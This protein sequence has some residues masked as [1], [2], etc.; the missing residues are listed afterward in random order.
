MTNPISPKIK[1]KIFALRAEGLSNEN[2]GKKLKISETTV[3][4]YLAK[5]SVEKSTTDSTPLT[6]EA[7]K[8]KR[9][10][11]TRDKR[12]GLIDRGLTHLEAM[13]PGID[14]P[15]GMRDW[16]VALGTAIDKRR[17]E[18]PESDASG[19]AAIDIFIEEMK[20]EAATNQP[21]AIEQH[22]Q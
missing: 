12:V 20:R 18:L 22:P 17:L 5:S 2:I 16:F 11:Y 7:A 19:V 8:N 6:N 1:K 14:K 21:E 10:E 13:L 4:R 15:S 9:M 3:R